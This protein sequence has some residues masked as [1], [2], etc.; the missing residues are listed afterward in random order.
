MKI[1]LALI[2]AAGAA[3]GFAV[4]R[5]LDK[6]TVQQVRDAAMDLSEDVTRH[7]QDIA[8]EVSELVDKAADTVSRN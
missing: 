8:T 3:I 2:L 1:I 4:F 5:R 7:A 6:D